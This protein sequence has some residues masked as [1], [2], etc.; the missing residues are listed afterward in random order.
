MN[1]RLLKLE[2]SEVAAANAA[3]GMNFVESEN[4]GE[5]RCWEYGGFVIQRDYEKIERKSIRRVDVSREP[6]YSLHVEVCLS[7]GGQFDPPE[8]DSVQLEAGQKHV[9]WLIFLAQ[10][11]EKWQDYINKAEADALAKLHAE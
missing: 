7:Y 4:H 3:T 6:R 2:D 11:H 5:V 8:Y 10:A 1:P 9:G